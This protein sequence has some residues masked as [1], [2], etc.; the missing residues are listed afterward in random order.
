[1]PAIAA[2]TLTDGASTPINHVFDPSSIL[3]DTANF[4]NRAGGVF[5]GNEL[6]SIRVVEPTSSRAFGRVILR[7]TMPTLEVTAG[8]TGSGIQAAPTKAYDNFLE[9]TFRF[10]GRSTEQERK[11]MRVMLIDL[12]GESIAVSSIE[13]LAP[14]Y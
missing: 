6:L 13:K 10:H 5:V 4:A 9:V 14:L 8:N 12:L 2:I 3:A 1:M 11:N 7:L